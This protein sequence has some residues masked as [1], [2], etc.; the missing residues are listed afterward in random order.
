MIDAPPGIRGRH[1]TIRTLFI[2]GVALLI[3]AVASGSLAR[4]LGGGRRQASTV[5]VPWPN[6]EEFVSV[7][8]EWPQTLQTNESAWVTISL[9]PKSRLQN[10]DFVNAPGGAA[11]DDVIVTATLVTTSFDLKTVMAEPQSV[12]GKSR[13]SWLWMI[14]T[15]YPGRQALGVLLYVERR[16]KGSGGLKDRTFLHGAGTEVGVRHPSQVRYLESLSLFSGALGLLLALLRPLEAGLRRM[17]ARS[18]TRT[19]RQ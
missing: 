15:K 5:Q 8:V 7:D 6:T 17:E 4:W 2:I 10:P 11:Q 16:S 1:G 18:T 12:R 19:G 9:V 3:I 13:V 14:S